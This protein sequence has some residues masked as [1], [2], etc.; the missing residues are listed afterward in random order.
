MALSQTA[1]AQNFD[2]VIRHRI[3]G[4]CSERPNLFYVG[5]FDH[6]WGLGGIGTLNLRHMSLLHRHQRN[7]N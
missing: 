1:P 2:F 5:L 4:P 6:Q 7:I 3:A